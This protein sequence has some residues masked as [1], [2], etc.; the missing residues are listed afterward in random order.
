MALSTNNAVKETI[1]AYRK[2]GEIKDEIRNHLQEDYTNEVDTKLYG[3]DYRRSEP[4]DDQ[5]LV[6]T[7]Y[8]A[9]QFL[10]EAYAKAQSDK[11]Y[12]KKLIEGIDTYLNIAE[13]IRADGEGK[14]YPRYLNDYIDLG[15]GD[16]D[17]SRGISSLSSS[18]EK[19]QSY[20]DTSDVPVLDTDWAASKYMAPSKDM[21]P[22]DQLNR[23]FS[24]TDYKSEDASI[25][26]H[27]VINPL[28]QFTRYAD[29]RRTTN[30]DTPVN[31]K[32]GTKY[33]ATGLGMG[34]YY[35][36]AIDDNNQ[37]I[38]F[39][40]GVPEFN[41]MLRFM[42]NASS[43]EDTYVAMHGRYP[44][45]LGITRTISTYF[46]A[47]IYPWK[48]MLIW[49]G[50]I[51]WKFI[52]GFNQVEYYYLNPSMHN[53]WGTV[54]TI[55]TSMAVELGIFVPELDITKADETD[56]S[57]RGMG[58]KV[59]WDKDA[60]DEL[61]ILLPGIFG[62]N[63]NYVDV[64]AIATRHQILANR[65]RE[66]IVRLYDDIS[67]EELE[68]LIGVVLGNNDT[69]TQGQLKKLTED[70]RALI[71][72]PSSAM[73]YI[74]NFRSKVAQGKIK[75]FD[76]FNTVIPAGL[77]SFA[78]FLKVLTGATDHG[79]NKD[80]VASDYERL[81][82]YRSGTREA[83][84]AAEA[85]DY[86]SLYAKYIVNAAEGSVFTDEKYSTYKSLGGDYEATGT[87]NAT[88]DIEGAKRITKMARQAYSQFDQAE[89]QAELQAEINRRD[90]QLENFSKFKKEVDKQTEE[91]K[92][93]EKK[94]SD[95][96]SAIATAI[97]DMTKW[98][99]SEG[100]G[101]G[102]I[103]GGHDSVMDQASQVVTA[104]Q[105]DGGLFVGMRVNPTR[106]ITDSF[107]NTHSPIQTGEFIRSATGGMKDMRFN[108][109]GGNIL[110]GM[111]DVL[112]VAKNV[113]I[114]TL[115][116]MTFGLTSAIASV[117]QGAYID[118]PDKW[119]ESNCNLGT[120]SYSIRLTAPY[121]N[122]ISQLQN[123]YIPLACLLAGV[124]PMQT[125][126]SS[127]TSPYL[128]SLFSKGVQ[129]IELGMITELSI[130]RATSNLPYSKWRQPLAIDVN[131][132]VTD[133]SRV[134]AAPINRSVWQAILQDGVSGMAGQLT[135]ETKM[136]D[137]IGVLCGR[138]ISNARF[139]MP[140]ISRRLR[141][142]LL[143]ATQTFT[144]MNAV[145]FGIGELTNLPAALAGILAGNTENNRV[146]S[147]QGAA[148]R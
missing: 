128:C 28:P 52:T 63:T 73:D 69:I 45:E 49:G 36:E 135:T 48:A 142:G 121:G 116:G 125:G 65:K 60:M 140:K 131:F 19:L 79:T 117:L 3:K 7:T 106:G 130:E 17:L 29:V 25:G 9:A 22:L 88:G 99:S 20:R 111:D 137:Y 8:E 104:V 124:L 115:D 26:N 30:P 143:R 105:M 82:D 15:K 32:H 16:I 66:G 56:A 91:G 23:F 68:N 57:Q 35:S 2:S 61:K 85:S 108:L 62:P 148:Q 4:E 71:E 133:F 37:S 101:M 5:E 122:A 80:K 126:K 144:N 123:I 77:N 90:K 81:A 54:N 120:A 141:K 46:A 136:D 53:Y 51:L 100:S 27:S 21:S 43:Y 76:P 72:P 39:Q 41:S 94:S 18:A 95:T 107:S 59:G 96:L 42:L 138:D 127:H 112:A 38:Y 145:A 64:Y 118:M 87:V 40:F 89:Y 12:A 55:V 78:N 14:S 13:Q 1:E 113:A 75:L 31:Q 50:Q 33:F 44:I 97:T 84:T 74:N 114:G 109:A 110:P 58:V 10:K 86:A 24:W 129:D 146:Q 70:P 93:N 34:R 134:L 98:L 67:N 132:T 147:N 102:K 83:R 103:F 11:E 119:D 139:E 92:K 47:R 6:K